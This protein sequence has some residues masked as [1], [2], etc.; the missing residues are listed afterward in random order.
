VARAVDQALLV[1]PRELLFRLA[2][3]LHR[4]IQP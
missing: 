4:A 2:D 1:A 3:E